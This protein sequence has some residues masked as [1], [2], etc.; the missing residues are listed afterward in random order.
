MARSP[1]PVRGTGPPPSTGL[2]T[3]S[4]KRES[5]N[6]PRIHVRSAPLSRSLE[7][8]S[9]AEASGGEVLPVSTAACAQGPLK[10]CPK[11]ALAMAVACHFPNAL[12]ATERS[13]GVV[14]G[15]VRVERRAPSGRSAAS[16]APFDSLAPLAAQGTRNWGSEVNSWTDLQRCVD[17]RSTLPIHA[18]PS[19]H[20]RHRLSR[21]W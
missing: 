9:L 11:I 1:G 8:G 20:H 3:G 6:E 21:R 10:V 5:Q 13:E 18:H 17:A 7:K 14:E 2:R 16:G 4:R 19:C 15:R 12:S